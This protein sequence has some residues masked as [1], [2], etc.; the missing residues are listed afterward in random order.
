MAKQEMVWRAAEGVQLLMGFQTTSRVLTFLLNVL[1]IRSVAKETV[2]AATS[3][4]QLLL[5]T[6][7]FVSREGCRRTCVRSVGD[8]KEKETSAPREKETEEIPRNLVWSCIVFGCLISSFFCWIFYGL[9]T[10]NELA[11]PN[12]AES[13]FLIA[14]AICLELLCEPFYLTFQVRFLF[15]ERVSI[16]ALALTLKCL[17]TFAFVYFQFGLL[18]FALGQLAHSLCLLIAYI[19]T[20]RNPFFPSLST[21]PFIDPSLLSL[22]SR[23]TW[24]TVQKV[25][26]TQ[27]ESVVLRY[28]VSLGGQGGFAVVNNL[29]SLVVRFLFTPF[30][31]VAYVLFSRVYCSDEGR[32]GEESKND[33]KA[34]DVALL[35]SLLQT[36]IV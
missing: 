19:Y 27:G 12:Y 18:S 30:E 5:M 24:Q 32:R 31:E 28:Y 29:G 4:T 20:L 7:L 35:R 8:G 14:I 25:V 36:S 23:F 3:L 16:E 22:W 33:D 10:P 6:C 11:I 26:L 21:R 15:R 9:S 1:I 34:R 17:A 2:G 13:L